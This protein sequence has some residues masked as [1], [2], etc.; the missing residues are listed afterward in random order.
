MAKIYVLKIGGSIIEDDEKLNHFI[1]AFSK[2]EHPTVLV[3]GGGK[4]ASQIAEKL[5][6]ASKM[7]EGRR[8]T[9]DDMLDIVTMT[10]GGLVN[11]KL[12]AR[13]QARKMDAI[14]LT[15]ADGNLI[16]SVKRP[17]ENDVDYGWVGKP[18]Q[19]NA[20]L[21]SKLITEGYT[22][23]V[24]PLTHDQEGQLF[25]TNADTMAN[26]ISSSLVDHFEVHTV[27]CFELAG[28]LRDINDEGSLIRN[29]NQKSFA[30]LKAEKVIHSGM[31]PKLENAL[32]AID[33]GV[34]SVRI[35]N[36]KDI[37]KLESDAGTIIS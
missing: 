8:V 6:F 18:V 22:P 19:V 11:K 10:Y 16:R 13:L 17:I 21:L 25:N 28:V 32:L 5:G 31:I 37:S 35:M 1:E 33:S 30:E 34:K 29:I 2:I 15:G 12:V 4:I 36:F 9:D 23:V 27:F 3:H 24:A 20:S 26:A 7:V 14:G